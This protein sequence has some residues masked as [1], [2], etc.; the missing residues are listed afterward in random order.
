VKVKVGGKCED[1]GRG[2][3]VKMGEDKD[4]GKGEGKVGREGCLQC[5][6][7]EGAIVA[8]ILKMMT[9]DITMVSVA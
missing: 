1:G 4:K 9:R 7:V 3:K 8:R 2:V 5:N 6:T